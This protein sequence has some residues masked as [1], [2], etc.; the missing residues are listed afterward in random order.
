[1]NK[2]ADYGS[3][4]MTSGAETPQ[5]VSAQNSYHVQMISE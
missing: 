5:L 4:N 1:M 2:T 3:F